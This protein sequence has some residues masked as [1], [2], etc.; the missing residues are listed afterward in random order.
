[1]KKFS[2]ITSL[3]LVTMTLLGAIPSYAQTLPQTDLSGFSPIK[4]YEQ[5]ERLKTKDSKELTIPGGQGTLT[6]NAWRSTTG[7]NSGNTIQWDYQVSAVYSGPKQVEKIRTTWQGQASLRNSASISLGIGDDSVSA[8][9]GSSWQ[10]TQT[11]S[12]FWE[13]SNGATTSDYGSNMIVTPAIDYRT[14]T[15]SITNTASVKLKG[16]PK[17]YSY[18]ASC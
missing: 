16:D 2:K 6:S 7:T 12:K 3:A 8:G 10:T 17:T 13:N 15:I 11:V 4:H 5:Q 1:M 9:G 18:S 14:G